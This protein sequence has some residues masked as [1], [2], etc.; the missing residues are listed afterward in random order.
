MFTEELKK[1]HIYFCFTFIQRKAFCSSN[2]LSAFSVAAYR[3][4]QHERY[5]VT[6][7]KN[8][9]AAFL[10]GTTLCLQVPKKVTKYFIKHYQAPGRNVNLV[11]L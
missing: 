2:S 6:I 8:V 11:S 7:W 4:D 1:K 9:K 10:Q 5:G 3:A